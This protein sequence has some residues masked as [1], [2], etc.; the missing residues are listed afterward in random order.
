[1]PADPK[2]GYEL[3]R[4]GALG[5]DVAAM[6]VLSESAFQ[7]GPHTPSLEEAIRFAD[8][9][10][11]CNDPRAAPLRERLAASQANRD[12][13]APAETSTARPL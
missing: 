2:T 13:T 4:R 6:I 3:I 12:A 5:G 9:A 11:E 10:E 8:M 1:M 7:S